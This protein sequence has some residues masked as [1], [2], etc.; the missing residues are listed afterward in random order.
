MHPESPPWIR[1]QLELPI[2]TSQFWSD[3]QIVIAYICN[4]SKRFKTFVANRVAQIRQFSEPNQWHYVSG[5]Q[6]PADVLSRGCTSDKVPLSWFRGPDFC[7]TT[8]AIG[9]LVHSNWQFLQVTPRCVN[10]LPVRIWPIPSLQMMS[11]WRQTTRLMH[12]SATIRAI[13]DFK[14]QFHGSPD[15]CGTWAT[16]MLK[17]APFR[18]QKWMTLIQRFC[19]L[20]SFASLPT[21][22]GIWSSM[23]R[24]EGQVVWV[25]CVL[26]C[27]PSVI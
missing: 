17:L 18:A 10:H 26:F 6:N 21:K 25:N 15:L 8:N 2:L 7:A 4:Q 16:N 14:R 3:S 9:P 22:F 24:S 5:D 1:K 23:E 12:W 20:S 27:V 11:L 19:G 13:T